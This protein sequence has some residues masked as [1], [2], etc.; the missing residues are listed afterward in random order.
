MDW[1]FALRRILAARVLA[2]DGVFA[3]LVGVGTLTGTSNAAVRHGGAS[4]AAFGYGLVALATAGLVVRRKAPLVAF[5][6]S[7]GAM[8]VYLALRY[9]FGPIVQVVGVTI[10][11]V[12]AWKDV[13]WSATVCGV[14]LAVYVPVEVWWSRAAVSVAGAA[15]TLAWTVLPWLAGLGMRAYRAV[16]AQLVAAERQRVGYQERLD[17]TR[18]VHDT[19]GHGLSVISM[20]AGIALHVLHEQPERV[21][22]GLLA[23]KAASGQALA[24]LRTALAVLPDGARQVPGLD[25]VATLAKAVAGEQL[26]VD[27]V[28]AGTR[29]PVPPAVDATGYRI[30]QESL[31]NVLRHAAARRAAVEV[32]YERS[33]VRLTITDDGR[34]GAPGTGG[35]GLA[36]MRERAHTLGGSVHA[37]PRPNGGFEVRAVLPW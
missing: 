18:D 28:V 15:V 2:V 32:R 33:A 23:I 30:V 5:G 17:I 21:E 4:M 27:V 29:G 6:V 34:G 9:P 12:G 19:V 16:R 10:Y 3:V 24:E 13:R 37:G 31:T 22:S 1:W 14:A 25:R 8:L 36:G 11:S 35:Q 20:H 7:Y 26:A